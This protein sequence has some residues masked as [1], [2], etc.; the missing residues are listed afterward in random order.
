MKCALTHFRS[1]FHRD[2]P[3][4]RGALLDDDPTTAL[5]GTGT[6]RDN[7]IRPCPQAK[8]RP[9]QKAHDRSQAREIPHEISE[10]KGHKVATLAQE[11]PCLRP[12]IVIEMVLFSQAN[13]WASNPFTTINPIAT[14]NPTA[15]RRAQVPNDRAR[16][17]SNGPCQAP[18]SGS[19]IIRRPLPTLA[20]QATPVHPRLPSA[21]HPLRL[22]RRHELGGLNLS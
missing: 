20:T 14:S 18:P 3:S 1:L 2:A 11:P 13:E 5:T 16:S 9:N 12:R 10:R 6:G 19:F 4:T 17:S 22:L 21:V 15:T 8:G 7:G